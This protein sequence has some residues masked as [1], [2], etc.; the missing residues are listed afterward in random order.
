MISAYV[1]FAKFK[2]L[3]IVSEIKNLFNIKNTYSLLLNSV[4]KRLKEHKL[5]FLDK[6]YTLY[7]VI[8]NTFNINCNY[9]NI[10]YR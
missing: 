4:F 10:L 3:R 7:R 8:K 5:N 6:Q 1:N 9:Q 2:I